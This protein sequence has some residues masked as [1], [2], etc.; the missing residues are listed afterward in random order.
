MLTLIVSGKF[1]VIKKNTQNQTKANECTFVFETNDAKPK[2][3]PFF[4]GGVLKGVLSWFRKQMYYMC[5]CV[6]VCVCVCGDS[7]FMI[8]DL[9]HSDCV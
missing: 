9:D 8:D 5:V 3:P 7:T 6:C 4:G 2:Q 1:R